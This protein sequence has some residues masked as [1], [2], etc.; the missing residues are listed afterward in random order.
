MARHAID[1][2]LSGA[3][4]ALLSH[5]VTA[6]YKLGDLDVLSTRTLRFKDYEGAGAFGRRIGQMPALDGLSLRER[7]SIDA[8]LGKLDKAV[9]TW[10]DAEQKEREKHGSA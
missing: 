6:C 3:Q 9:L 2:K 5:E 8:V 7:R 1:L 4:W 10:L